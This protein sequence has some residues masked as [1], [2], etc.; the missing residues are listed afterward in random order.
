MKI[1]KRDK[2][3]IIENNRYLSEEAQGLRGPQSQKASK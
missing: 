3:Q 2:R 1:A